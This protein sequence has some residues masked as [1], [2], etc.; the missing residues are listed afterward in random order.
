LKSSSAMQEN[1]LVQE[2]TTE[3]AT[4]GAGE[5]V[6]KTEVGQEPQQEEPQHAPQ[7]APQHD[8]QQDQVQQ[9]PR[10][11]P[12]EQWPSQEPPV[13]QK[14]SVQQEP[15]TS[16]AVPFSQEPSSS[17]EAQNAQKET[18]P[19]AKPGKFR[20]FRLTELPKNT[21][22]TSLLEALEHFLAQNGENAGEDAISG[23]SVAPD[24]N[25]PDSYSIATVTFAEEPKI[26]ATKF[27]SCSDATLRLKIDGISCS[28]Q[29]DNHFTGLTT[30]H[31]Y[32]PVVEYGPRTFLLPCLRR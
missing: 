4:S 25:D 28:V 2:P 7:Q 20:A 11:V 29:I 30:L 17:Q 24:Q 3:E 32:E 31:C 16:H 12:Q 15:P 13:Q 14:P 23:L 27:A 18:K 21:T 9:Q 5:A 1:H 19:A 10:D 26:L 6:H 8:Q 22:T